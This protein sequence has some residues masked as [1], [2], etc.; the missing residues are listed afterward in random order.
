MANKEQVK[1]IKKGSEVWNLWRAENSGIRVDFEGVNLSD[2]DFSYVNLSYAN[3]RDADLSR[4]RLMR[5]NLRFAKFD[6]ANL[7][8][9]DLEGA[10]LTGAAF[11]EANLSHI[12]LMGVDLE[13]ADL[14][15]TQLSHAN[16]IK[17]NLTSAHLDEA[18]LTGAQLRNANLSNAILTKAHLEGADLTHANLRN[19][20]LSGADLTSTDLMQAS[21]SGAKLNGTDLTDAQI[22]LTELAN[23]DLST[24][25]GLLTIIHAAPSRIGVDTLFKS[26][27]NI[28]DLFLRGVGLPE[29]FI[30]FVPSLV[31]RAIE[32]YSCFISYSHQDEQFSQRLYSRMRSE[33]LRV[34][35]APEDMKGGRKLHEEIFRA[36]Q[37]HDKLLLVLSKNSM[38]SEWVGTEIRRARKVE[39]EENRRKLFPIRLTS[40]EAIQQWQCFDADSGRDLAVELREYYIPD[41]SNWKDHDVFEREF[42]KLLRDLKSTTI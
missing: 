35:Y 30:S 29:D 7:T 12:S 36:I 6:R 27:G 41:F 15:W 23:I 37:I 4:T 14:K 17:V 20:D 25:K 24:V 34:W 16:L 2:V 13:E 3:L 18:W 39:G 5:A 33:N 11:N 19:A 28:P 31:G 9:A 22:G 26:D 42:G 8:R 40:Y 1:L 10:W 32:F 21:L 38:N